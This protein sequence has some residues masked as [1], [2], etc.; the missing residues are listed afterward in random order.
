MKAALSTG[1][2]ETVKNVHN[3][4]LFLKRNITKQSE[5]TLYSNIVFTALFGKRGGG[6]GRE[7]DAHNL[8]DVNFYQLIKW[9]SDTDAFSDYDIRASQSASKVMAL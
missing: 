7:W 2:I 8:T 5:S 6:G 3:I 1:V 4:A 9:K